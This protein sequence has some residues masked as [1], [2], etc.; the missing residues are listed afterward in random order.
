MATYFKNVASFEDLKSQFRELARANHPDAGGDPE[1]MK[2]INQEFDTLFPIWRHRFNQTAAEQNTETADSTRAHFYTQN[3]WAGSR[4]ELNRTTKEVAALVRAY[5]KET[6]PTF[7]FS[8][9]YSS[10]SMCSEV[11]TEMVEAP[12]EPYKTFDE[13]TEDEVLEVWSK[14]GRN[15]WVKS[16]ILDDKTMQDLR[17][18]YS[19]HKFLKVYTEYVEAVIKDVEREVNTYRYDDSDGMIDYF[20]CNFYYFGCKLSDK[21]KVVQKTARIKNQANE[22]KTTSGEQETAQELPE[23][24]E[25][26]DYDIQKT[27]HTKTHET[28]WTVKVIRKLSREEYLKVAEMMKQIGGYYSRYVHAFVFKED[29]TERLVAA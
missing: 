3:G 15:S 22:V 2:A 6:Y 19:E 12:V 24:V 29:P 1:I 20:S 8:V 9:R 4:Y 25:A 26:E 27:E 7:K 14:A 11:H 28:I 21:F 17:E 13:L 10:A 23:S 16:D 5:V 18:A